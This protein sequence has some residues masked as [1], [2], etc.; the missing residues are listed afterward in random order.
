MSSLLFT[1]TLVNLL[2]LLQKS[3]SSDSLYRKCF[4][5]RLV[6]RLRIFFCIAISVC[7][8]HVDTN[9]LYLK[10]TREKERILFV[11]SRVNMKEGQDR[12]G[13][14]QIGRTVASE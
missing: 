14:D 3:L 8:V 4:A 9:L 6:S 13:P 12:V 2:V 11:V 7:N 1:S 10:E 5:E